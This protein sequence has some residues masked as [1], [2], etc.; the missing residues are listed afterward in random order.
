M[1]QYYANSEYVDTL[2]DAH[3]QISGSAAAV[4]CNMVPVAIGSQTAGST[5]RPAHFSVSPKEQPQPVDGPPRSK[6][7]LN[8][9][10]IGGKVLSH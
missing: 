7:P 1:T 4:A 5:T 8:Y 10:A 2:L 6:S 9:F 3:L